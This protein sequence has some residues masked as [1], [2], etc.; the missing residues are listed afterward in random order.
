MC[1]VFLFYVA[2]LF[3]CWPMINTLPAVLQVKADKL[4]TFRSVT[5]PA[6]TQAPSNTVI[7]SFINALSSIRHSATWAA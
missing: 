5:H 3:L 7:R 2:Q 6:L 4:K 1:G